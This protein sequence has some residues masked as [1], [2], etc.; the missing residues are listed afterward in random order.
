M[1][2]GM[3][4]AGDAEWA[5]QACRRLC[6]TRAWTD[7]RSG[8]GRMSASQHGQICS[9]RCI[10]CREPGLP[11]PWEPQLDD[12]GALDLDWVD[13]PLDFSALL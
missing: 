11:R 13:A 2:H 3:E 4:G 6:E 1:G 7:S 10:R 5:R 9:Q 8:P 12:L